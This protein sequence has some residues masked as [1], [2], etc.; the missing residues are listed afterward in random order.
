ML[1]KNSNL[2]PM[3]N[4]NNNCIVDNFLEGK[5]KAVDKSASAK[6]TK[7]IKKK[8]LDVFISGIGCFIGTFWLQ[9][10]DESKPYQRLQ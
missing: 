8:F 7:L 2:I 1:H 3:V 4:N 10:K 6:L 9:V 5:N